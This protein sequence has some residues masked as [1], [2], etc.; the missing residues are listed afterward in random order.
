MNKRSD[1]F[2]LAA[3]AVTM[4]VVIVLLADQMLTYAV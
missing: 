3:M 1:T 2:S 4:L